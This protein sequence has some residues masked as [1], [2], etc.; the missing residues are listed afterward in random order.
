[1][2]IGGNSIGNRKY[3]SYQ[4]HCVFVGQLTYHGALAMLALHSANAHTKL[5]VSP[6]TRSKLVA[7][8]HTRSKLAF[9][10]VSNSA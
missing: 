1:M 4:I 3:S 8:P 7:S 6:R 5:A 2:K 9:N 10:L